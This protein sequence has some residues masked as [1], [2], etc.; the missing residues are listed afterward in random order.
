VKNDFKLPL[1]AVMRMT[2]PLIRK[3]KFTPNTH[4][5]RQAPAKDKA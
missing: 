2:K 5:W 4:T 3:N 1:L